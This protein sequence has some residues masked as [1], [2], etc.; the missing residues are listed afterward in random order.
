LM[1][2]GKVK[3]DFLCSTNY[4]SIFFNETLSQYNE[5]FSLV[6]ELC[7]TLKTNFVIH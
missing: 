4:Q 6:M 3:L 5:L 7:F 1:G 2:P